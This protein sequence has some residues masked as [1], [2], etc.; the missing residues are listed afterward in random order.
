MTSLTAEAD[1]FDTVLR[2]LTPVSE[3]LALFSD[4][5]AAP[6]GLRYQ[7]GFITDQSEQELIAQIRALPLAPFQFGAFEGKRPRRLFRVAP[8]L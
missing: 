8:R 6:R 7:P 5:A 4:D 3:Q 2:Q 1:S